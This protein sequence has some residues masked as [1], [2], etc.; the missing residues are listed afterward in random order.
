MYIHP[1]NINVP[2]NYRC[3]SLVNSSE[4]RIVAQ[5]AD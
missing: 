5:K 2:K 4:A 1:A 3:S